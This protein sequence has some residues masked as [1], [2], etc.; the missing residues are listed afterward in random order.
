MNK[1]EVVDEKGTRLHTDS[2]YLQGA[3]IYYYRELEQEGVIAT[4]KGRGSVVAERARPD[5][6][7][8]LRAHLGRVVDGAIAEARKFDLDDDAI[9]GLVEDRLRRVVDRKKGGRHE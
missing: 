3:F 1:G 7:R 2:H 4:Q 6:E 9:R 5:A 8:V